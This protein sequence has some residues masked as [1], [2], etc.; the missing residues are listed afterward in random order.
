MTKAKYLE[1]CEETGE[2]P[3][4]HKMP[5]DFE[6]FP[7]AVHVAFDL[8]NKLPDRYLSGM[9]TLFI[10]KDYGS[11]ETFFNIYEVPH[12]DRKLVMDVILYIDSQ[13]RIKAQKRAEQEAKKA[14]RK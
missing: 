2:E 1:Y 8:Y 6:D 11:L 5:P 7:Y 14:A 10:G 4:Y 3:D 12:A 13:A 9:S